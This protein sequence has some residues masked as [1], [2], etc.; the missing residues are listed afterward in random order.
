M[1]GDIPTSQ[2]NGNDV[3]EICGQNSTSGRVGWGCGGNIV[4]GVTALYAQLVVVKS[5]GGN[6]N[7]VVILISL[8][9]VASGQC[10]PRG[11]DRASKVF[12]AYDTDNN[13]RI[14]RNEGIMTFRI[15]DSNSDGALTPDEFSTEWTFYNSKSYMPFFTAGDRNGDGKID[16]KEGNQAFDYF[17][18]NEDNEITTLEFSRTWEY[19]DNYFNSNGNTEKK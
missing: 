8:F 13:S 6:I 12:K 10:I 19:L 18:N 4:D 11:L 14:S 16:F 9:A 5:C 1:A 3:D 2:C 7:S 15:S 17:D